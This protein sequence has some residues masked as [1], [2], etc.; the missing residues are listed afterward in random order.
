[1]LPIYVTVVGS[2]LYGISKPDSDH[3]IKGIGFN[4][5]DEYIGLKN[6]EQQDYNN[7]KEGRES[8]N[9][10][11]YDVRRVFHL[12]FKGNPTVLEPFFAPKSCII[13]TCDIGEEIAAFVRANLVTKHFFQPY[14]GYHGSQIKEFTNSNRTGKRKESFE[15][16][17]YDGKFAGHAYR[18]AKQCVGLMRDGVLNPMLEGEDRTIV[19]NMRNHYYSKEECLKYL[20]DTD[21]EMDMAV[22]NSTLPDK[23]D[24]NYINDFVMDVVY[25]YITGV[26]KEQITDFDINYFKPLGE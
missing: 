23:P 19:M 6:K 7:G 4:Y 17:G 11:V 5:V 26:Y 15:Q 8:F 10:T 24:F 13:H 1:M 18:L 20:Q 2:Q 9:G 25:N 14:K 3:D 12:L 22:A 21:M 16:Y